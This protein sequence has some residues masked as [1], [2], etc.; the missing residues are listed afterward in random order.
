LFPSCTLSRAPRD[1]HSFPTRRSSDLHHRAPEVLRGANE[2]AGAVHVLFPGRVGLVPRPE[3]AQPDCPA[4]L[5]ADAA[6][7]SA[8][9]PTSA[10]HSPVSLE[11]AGRCH[12]RQEP[13]AVMPHVRICGGGYGQPSSL[14]RLVLV[15]TRTGSRRIP[16]RGSAEWPRRAAAPPSARSPDRTRASRPRARSSW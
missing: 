12:L 10:H 14:L 11:A 6:A 2:Q 9:A 3:A 16:R 4:H 8:L 13:D 1:L 5:G 7:H 15:S